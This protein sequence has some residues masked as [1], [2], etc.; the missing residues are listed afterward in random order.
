M[1]TLVAGQTKPNFSIDTFGG[2]LMNNVTC[3]EL[4]QPVLGSRC[5][6]IVFLKEMQSF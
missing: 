2:L 4:E 6:Q 5:R 1:D 3:F